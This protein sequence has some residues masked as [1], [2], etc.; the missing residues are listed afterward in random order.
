V[1]ALIDLNLDDASLFIEPVDDVERMINSYLPLNNSSRFWNE[2]TAAVKREGVTLDLK[3]VR[4]T[5]GTSIAASA[6]RS[7]PRTLE[8]Q[9]VRDIG[10]NLARDLP[11]GRWTDAVA[12]SDLL[13]NA[14]ALDGVTRQVANAIGAPGSVPEWWSIANP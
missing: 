13:S 4:T 6:E 2:L 11:I 7:S 12:A 14:I 8:I 1:E 9:L 3:E 5:F 10:A